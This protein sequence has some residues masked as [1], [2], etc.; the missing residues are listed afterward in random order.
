VLGTDRESF[1]IKSVVS[2][3]LNL[4][5]GSNVLAKFASSYVDRRLLINLPDELDEKILDVLCLPGCFNGWWDE[6][7]RRGRPCWCGRRAS[8]RNDACRRV[9][10]GMPI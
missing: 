2:I 6:E 10:N 9:W 4:W 5:E 1:L 3:F 7:I 8:G